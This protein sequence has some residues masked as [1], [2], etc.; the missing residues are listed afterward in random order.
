MATASKLMLG[1]VIAAV[2]IASPALAQYAFQ[3]D[4]S[5]SVHHSKYL[6]KSAHRSGLHTFA[7]VPVDD[8]ARRPYPAVDRDVPLFDR[9]FGGQ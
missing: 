4:P 6:R 9:S 3:G 5:I 1:A 7:V 2:S 8:P